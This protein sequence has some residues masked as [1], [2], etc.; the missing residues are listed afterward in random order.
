MVLVTF[1]ISDISRMCKVKSNSL[2]KNL[3]TLP[4]SFFSMSIDSP[5]GPMALDVLV[6]L[7]AFATSECSK[8]SSCRSLISAEV[9]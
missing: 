9:A 7:M 8:V 3:I 6:L 4:P 2:V 1:Q 5:S